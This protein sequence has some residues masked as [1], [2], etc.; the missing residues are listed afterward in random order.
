[1]L[2]KVEE[3]RMVQAP[4]FEFY[5]LTK[6][7]E[8]FELFDK[9]EGGQNHLVAILWRQIKDFFVGSNYHGGSIRAISLKVVPNMATIS[10]KDSE[11]LSNRHHSVHIRY[12]WWEFPG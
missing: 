11:A 5:F 3:N 8:K 4:K 10:I 7:G 2:V 1:M 12:T 9:K 6:K